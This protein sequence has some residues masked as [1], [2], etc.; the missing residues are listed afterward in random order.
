MNTKALFIA[1]SLS[2]IVTVSIGQSKDEGSITRLI[3]QLFEGMKKGD[4]TMVRT[5]FTKDVS[6]ATVYRS[7][8]GEPAIHFEKSLDD[9]VKAVGTPHT[10]VWTEEYW[11]LKIQIDGDFASAWCDYA[12]YLDH[13]FSHCGVD[14]FHLFKSKDGWKIFHLADTRRKE[15][16]NIPEHISQKHPKG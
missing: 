10:G 12:F 14:V 15:N 9:F 11:N 4:S 6:L 5:A 3:E 1:I 7:K 2:F 13:T 8:A 16:C